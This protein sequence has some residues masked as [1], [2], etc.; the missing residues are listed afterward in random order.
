MAEMVCE[1]F[2]DHFLDRQCRLI[3]KFLQRLAVAVGKFG[4]TNGREKRVV[5]CGG[6]ARCLRQ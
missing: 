1:P 2:Q 6:S 5:R 4:T 3:K